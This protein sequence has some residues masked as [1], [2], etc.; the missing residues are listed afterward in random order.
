MTGKHLAEKGQ[1]PH[2][3]AFVHSHQYQHHGEQGMS[4]LTSC[5]EILAEGGCQIMFEEPIPLLP[6]SPGLFIL[7]DPV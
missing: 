1:N 7:A 5:K 4:M 6:M 2:D 3:C